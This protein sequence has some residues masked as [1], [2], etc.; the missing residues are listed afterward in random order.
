MKYIGECCLLILQFHDTVDEFACIVWPL[1]AQ[2]FFDL[3]LVAKVD[4]VFRPMAQSNVLWDQSP[5]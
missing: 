5:L 2:A 4:H 1:L 3:R